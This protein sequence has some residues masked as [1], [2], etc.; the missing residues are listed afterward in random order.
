M[1]PAGLNVAPPQDWGE[2]QVH[3]PHASSVRRAMVVAL[4]G[5]EQHMF[6][7]F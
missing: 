4:V 2:Q 3:F 1:A 7:S 5:S 6:A